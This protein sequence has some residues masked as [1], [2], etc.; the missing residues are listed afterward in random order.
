MSTLQRP[1]KPVKHTY[2]SK[3]SRQRGLQS[4]ESSDTAVGSDDPEVRK[5]V[6]KRKR[7]HSDDE[8]YDEE[9]DEEPSKSIPS[10]YDSPLFP[11]GKKR[12]TAALLV[13]SKPKTKKENRPSSSSG[14][15]KSTTS[16]QPLTQLH[17]SF[18]S[19]IRTCKSCGLSYTRGSLDDEQLHKK[20]CA[21]VSRG[22][23]WG[24]EEEKTG[25]VQVIDDAARTKD[26][27]RGRVVC[28]DANV[29]GKLHSKVSA[30]ICFCEPELT[31]RALQFTTLMETINFALSAPALP[32]STLSES[33]MYL[34]LLTPDAASNNREKIIGC[35]VASRIKTAMRVVPKSATD[36]SQADKDNLVWVDGEDGGIFCDPTPLPTPLGIPRLFVPSEYRHQGVASALLTA[37]ARTFVYGCPL[38]PAKGQVAFS[39]PTGAGRGVMLNWGK[40][41][42]RIFQE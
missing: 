18:T 14:A 39:Q 8:D 34:F 30:A 35:V 11:F 1:S 41:G 40:G 21:R 29:K 12:K 37:A 26:G 10:L 13:P 36:V 33:K 17:L 23:E 28:F 5:S 27:R 31:P 4:W 7:V 15:S 25:N 3:A 16:S 38:D 42:V 20:H 9:S 22:M 32:P 2:A 6:I 24:R 19:S